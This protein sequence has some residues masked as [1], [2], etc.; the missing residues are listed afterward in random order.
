MGKV[1]DECHSEDV[2]GVNENDKGAVKRRLQ[3][4]QEAR[5]VKKR[6]VSANVLEV[7]RWRRG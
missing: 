2:F 3:Q 5:F 7:F 1:D 6:K 4:L